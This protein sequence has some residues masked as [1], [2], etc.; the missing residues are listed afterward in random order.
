MTRVAWEKPAL[1]GEKPYVK[2]KNARIFLVDGTKA[3][4]GAL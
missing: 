2:A 3:S 1:S 4:L